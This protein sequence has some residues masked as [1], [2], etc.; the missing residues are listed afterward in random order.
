MG[1]QEKYP[2]KDGVVRA[3]YPNGKLQ[4]SVTY[5]NG[6]MLGPYDTYHESGQLMESGTYVYNKWVGKYYMYDEE[7]SL[8]RSFT[9]N[10]QGKRHGLQRYYYPNGRLQMLSK[11]Q[12]DV[13]EGYF[14]EFDSL[15]HLEERPVYYI[16][17]MRS[18]YENPD[19]L[20][21][22]LE[23]ARKENEALLGRRRPI[24]SLLSK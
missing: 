17:G 15:G 7:G 18:D 11:L 6:R 8:L 22:M 13:Q 2:A 1:A 5:R 23:L 14:L 21:Q 4:S 9:Y 19:E 10:A 3:Y 16:N 20:E 24:F 12:N